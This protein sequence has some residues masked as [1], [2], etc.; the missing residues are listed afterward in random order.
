MDEKMMKELNATLD[1][2]KSLLA[3]LVAQAHETLEIKAAVLSSAGLK[4]KE[5]ATVCGSTPKSISVRLAEAKR[6]TNK[7]KR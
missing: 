3:H 1:T 7:S 2:I 5:I 6:K 4:A